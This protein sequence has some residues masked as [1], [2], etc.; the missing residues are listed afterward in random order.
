MRVRDLQ[1]TSA[2]VGAQSLL[3]SIALTGASPVACLESAP[4]LVRLSIIV[5]TLEA[6]Y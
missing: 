2:L 5:Y 4:R 1:Y 6:P 3:T